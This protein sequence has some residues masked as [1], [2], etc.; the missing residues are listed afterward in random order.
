M[1]IYIH[2]YV[3]NILFQGIKIAPIS[4]KYSVSFNILMKYLIRLQQL[5]QRSIKFPAPARLT[6]T[7]EMRF[8][9]YTAINITSSLLILTEM[10][11][12]QNSSKVHG[13]LRNNIYL[14]YDIERL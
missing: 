10:T 1:Q 2:I 13:N 9:V 3:Y 12:F 5:L 4:S 6:K 7:V 8:Y 11:D 14:S